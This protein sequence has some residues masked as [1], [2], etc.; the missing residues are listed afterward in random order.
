M[1]FYIYI[2]DLVCLLSSYK[3]VDEIEILINFELIRRSPI[4]RRTINWDYC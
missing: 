2:Y 4:Q 3:T 1:M